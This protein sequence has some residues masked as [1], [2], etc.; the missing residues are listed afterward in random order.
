MTLAGEAGHNVLE[1]ASLMG[2]TEI[3]T[4]RRCVWVLGGEKREAVNAAMSGRYLLR[5]RRAIAGM[6]KTLCG[7]HVE[8]DQEVLSRW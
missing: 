2:Y 1:V 6:L 7:L 5:P 8:T 4:T 3:H